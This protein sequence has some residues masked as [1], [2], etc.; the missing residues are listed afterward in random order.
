MGKVILEGYIVVPEDDLKAVTAALP[1]HIELTRKEVGCLQFEVTPKPGSP[2][3]FTVY[4]VFV[5]R[6]AFESHQQRVRE[7][8]WGAITG[9]VERH[10]E[11]R[12]SD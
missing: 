8:A 12:E 3:V 4:E 5:D 6:F 1:T 9:Q 11:I 10:Y 7:S 2:N